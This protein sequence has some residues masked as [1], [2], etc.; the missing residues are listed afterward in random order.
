M[1]STAYY[2]AT[3]EYIISRTVPTK[4]QPSM[5]IILKRIYVELWWYAAQRLN[6][7]PEQV[8]AGSNGWNGGYQGNSLL[9]HHHLHHHHHHFHHC[10]HHQ[11]HHHFHLLLV[12][13][14]MEVIKRILSTCIKVIII[15]LEKNCVCVFL[16]QSSKSAKKISV[17]VCTFIAENWLQLR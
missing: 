12:T 6:V 15:Q 8:E 16:I 13:D 1:Y 11:F 9:L 17:C 14:W 7:S 2:A 5:K 3:I 10:H 4:R